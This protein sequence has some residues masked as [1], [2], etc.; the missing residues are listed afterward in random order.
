MSLIIRRDL[1]VITV[2][3]LLRDRFLLQKMALAL[4]CVVLVPE[5]RGTLVKS[6]ILAIPI[7]VCIPEEENI[8]PL[9][10]IAN[11]V[12]VDPGGNSRTS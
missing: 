5:G 12:V 3:F 2:G 4:L 11:V 1:K 6:S 8:A 10:R 9:L 7:E